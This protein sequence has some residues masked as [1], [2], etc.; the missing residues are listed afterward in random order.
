MGDQWR[1]KKYLNEEKGNLA[2][3][4][5]KIRLNMYNQ[6]SNFKAQYENLSCPRCRV[7]K[8]T[9]E[10]VTNCFKDSKIQR[11]KIQNLFPTKKTIYIIKF[12]NNN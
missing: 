5:L 6:K 7:N 9:T 2:I 8:D 11:F 3:T 10:H 12:T 4:I 1:R